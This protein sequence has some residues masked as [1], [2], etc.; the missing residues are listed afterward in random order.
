MRIRPPIQP[1][2]CDTPSWVIGVARA[3]PTRHAYTSGPPDPSL[4][5]AENA[6]H[7]PS[8]EYDT[9]APMTTTPEAIARVCAA[10]GAGV[11]G[12]SVTSGVG[13]ADGVGAALAGG[14]AEEPTA[15][16]DEGAA[17]DSD[18]RPLAV[19]P[20]E[21]SAGDAPGV[22]WVALGVSDG[23]ADPLASALAVGVGTGSAGVD[24][25]RDPRR[26]TR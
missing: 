11:G 8:V 5:R 10:V 14:V 21:A 19:A 16:G 4:G 22:S 12:G 15:G 26:G 17:G 2:N 13:A 25:A 9:A 20:G 24:A 23:G 6:T 18:G 3:E 7:R 1:E